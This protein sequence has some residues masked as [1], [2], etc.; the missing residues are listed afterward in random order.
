MKS[1]EI[2]EIPGKAENYFC[3]RNL[4]ISFATF[5]PEAIA[6]TIR[7]APLTESPAAKTFSLFVK[8]VLFTLIFFLLVGI[9]AYSQ[10]PSPPSAQGQMQRG[11][12]NPKD[13][14]KSNIE[15]KY[16]NSVPP[17]PASQINKIDT[18]KGDAAAQY[19]DKPNGNNQIIIVKDDSPY[20]LWIVI[21]TGLLFVCNVLLWFATM[22][23]ANA[24]KKSAAALPAIERAYVFIDKSGDKI[25]PY[26]G[27][28]S[29]VPE[30]CSFNIPIILSNEGKTPAI[31]TKI[32]AGL[33]IT[34]DNLTKTILDNFIKDQEIPFKDLRVNSD[35]RNIRSSEPWIATIEVWGYDNQ[36]TEFFDKKIVDNSAKPLKVFC[37]GE[38]TYRDVMKDTHHTWFCWQYSKTGE[39]FYRSDND[40]LN[41]YD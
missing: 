18:P 3:F 4:S 25:Y 8:W 36:Y 14:A 5:L 1:E 40:E 7:V 12:F 33:M 41:D 10:E 37:C 34:R 39:Y 32:C 30:H 9:S 15:S 19:R 21:F 16:N 28:S 26:R 20:T 24:A 22:R 17:N 31:I 11:K 35:K 23:A 6:F 13:N 38:I 2:C 27:T 29:G